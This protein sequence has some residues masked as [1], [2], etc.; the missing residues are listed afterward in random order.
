M[1]PP[2][3]QPTQSQGPITV[4]AGHTIS[5]ASITVLN[6]HGSKLVRAFVAGDKQALT[7]TQRLWRLIGE[8]TLCTVP[9]IAVRHQSQCSSPCW[10][11]GILLES[12]GD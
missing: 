7:V 12:A 11:A 10:C 8:C 1:D 2:A 3:P 6:G 9:H 4:T 5:E